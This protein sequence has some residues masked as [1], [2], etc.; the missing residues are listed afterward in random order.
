MTEEIDI[1]GAALLRA[2]AKNHAFVTVVSDHSDYDR[3]IEELSGH[4]RMTAL[5][6]RRRLA[7][8]AFARVAAYDSAIATWFSSILGETPA[9]MVSVAGPLRQARPGCRVAP[10]TA[11]PP[12]SEFGASPVNQLAGRRRGRWRGNRYATGRG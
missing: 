3:V 6:T 7:A 5:A 2:A 12:Q 11:M 4:G 10:T 9:A 8:K 1:G